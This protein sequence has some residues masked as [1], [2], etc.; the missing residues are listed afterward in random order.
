MRYSPETGFAG[1]S[2]EILAVK[3]GVFKRDKIK[4]EAKT[5]EPEEII[6]P[7][8]EKAAVSVRARFKKDGRQYLPEPERTDTQTVFSG[9]N[10]G[11]R[12]NID[13]VEELG[14]RE[15]RSARKRGKEIKYPNKDVRRETIRDME[16]L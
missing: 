15:G 5:D 6:G 13:V 4:P 2:S 9:E 11:S 1:G 12:K 3:K 16:T 7:K 8:K 10:V 14:I